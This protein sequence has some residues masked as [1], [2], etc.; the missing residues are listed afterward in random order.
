MREQPGHRSDRAML[1][2]LSHTDAYFDASDGACAP[3]DL[4]ALGVRLSRLFADRFGGDRSS[5]VR[6]CVAEVARAL[7]LRGF[8]R[9]PSPRR[10]ALE[11][12]APLLSLIDDLPR[13][14]ERDR[15]RVARIVH[16]KGARSE[17]SAD[18]LLLA[19]APLREALRALA[20]R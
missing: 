19:H 12:L 11:I 1:H 8:A 14:P 7:S 20:A 6:R 10:R 4:G 16:A 15:H 9:W 2:R 5:G 17:R 18:R 3:L 13:W